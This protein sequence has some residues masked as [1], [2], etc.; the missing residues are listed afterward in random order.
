MFVYAMRGGGYIKIGVSDDIERRLLSFNS[1]ALPF[2]M[3]LICLGEADTVSALE[4]E[5]GLLRAM[6][7]LR[8]EWVAG[9]VTDVEVVSAFE[10]WRWDSLLVTPTAAQVAMANRFTKMQRQLEASRAVAQAMESKMPKGVDWHRIATELTNSGD[11]AAVM[12]V[13]KAFKSKRLAAQHRASR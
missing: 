9:S 12:K 3:S 1:G 6:P 10:A 2:E 8:G 11:K 4:M 7:R 5:A 13:K